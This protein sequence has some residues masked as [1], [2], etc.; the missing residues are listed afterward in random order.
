MLLMTILSAVGRKCEMGQTSSYPPN[1][2]PLPTGEAKAVQWHILSLDE[3]PETRWQKIVQP[4]SEGIEELTDIVLD[5]VTTLLGNYTTVSLLD[6]IDSRL[7]DYYAALPNPDFG[8][9][10]KGIASTTG[11]RESM[12]FVYNIF[13]TVF[14][15]CTSV[16]AQN[17]DGQIWHAR[18]LDFG[19]W[20]A[21]NF[22]KGSFWEMSAALRPLVVNVD[23]QRGGRTV[24]KQTTFA[25]FI[26]AHTAMKPGAFGLTIDSRFDDHFD[27]GLLRFLHEPRASHGTEITL[28]SRH[29][30]E[31]S[32]NFFEAFRY[33]NSTQILGPGYYI[34]SGVNKGE[35]AVITKGAAK[36][37]IR[38]AEGVTIDVWSLAEEQAKPAGDHFLLETNYDHWSAVSPIDDRRSPAYDCLRKRLGGPPGY[39]ATGLFNVLSAVPNLNKLT[40]FT[41]LMQSDEGRFEA[42]RQF[43]VSSAKRR[44]PLF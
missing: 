10:I 8:K 7:P 20:P 31:R 19:L 43:C 18:N 37:G 28:L 23:V 24:Y 25:G 21:F 16:V 14:G 40:V 9:E 5:A 6:R 38:A 29:A 3:P 12:M 11:V 32:G 35:G 30:F 42:Y 41:T 36:Q 33:L 26:G 34:L 22:T 44:C 2:E 15:A 13:Y 39:N 27:V 4:H 1:L 17:A